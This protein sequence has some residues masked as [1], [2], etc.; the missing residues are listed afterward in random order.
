MTA[1]PRLRPFAVLAALLLAAPPAWAAESAPVQS[2]RATVA[3]VSDTD[4]VAPGTPFH[5]GLRV[6]MA[7][8]W[9][10]YWRNP[11]EAGAP[12]EIALRLPAGAT[13]GPIAWPAP[14][15]I[16]EGPVMTD[17]YAGTVLLPLK[18]TPPA[19][20]GAARAGRVS[21]SRARDGSALR[22]RGTGQRFARAGRLS[23]PRRPAPASAACRDS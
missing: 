13:E 19:A 10:T 18:V 6:A 17:A 22:A 14:R 8:G 11:G 1:L 2:P 23:V 15:R 20:A 12:P 16:A 4:Q 9:H 5:L 7:P 21:A 3:L